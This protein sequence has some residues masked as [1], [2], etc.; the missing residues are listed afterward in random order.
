M[1]NQNSEQSLTGSAGLEKPETVFFVVHPK[2]DKP[3][4]GPFL[5]HNAAEF[6]RIAIRHPDAAVEVRTVDCMDDS[7]RIR[8]E[9]RGRVM[10]AFVDRQGV[11]HG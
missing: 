7:T 4:L 2:S 5:S 3:L 8:A 9:A 6:G 10:C 11:N 1:K